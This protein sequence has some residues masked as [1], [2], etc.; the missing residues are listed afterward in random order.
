MKT[1]SRCREQLPA[2]SFNK[3]AARKD[4]LNN[5]CKACNREL[6]REWRAKNPK[7][8]RANSIRSTQKLKET[9]P[10]YHRD[11]WKNYYDT[12]IGRAKVT[13]SKQARRKRLSECEDNYT[14]EEFAEL[15]ILYGGACLRCERTDVRLTVDH[16]IPL[17]KGGDNSIQNIQPLCGPCNSSKGNRHNTDY[18]SRFAF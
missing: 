7:R 13:A 2:E 16:V 14:A 1:C 6:S 4:G 3:C 15:C 18:R 11:Y 10:D 17:S 5:N 8:A 12:E 9:N